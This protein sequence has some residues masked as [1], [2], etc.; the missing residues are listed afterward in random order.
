MIT[1]RAVAVKWYPTP[2][3]FLHDAVN[4]VSYKT[5]L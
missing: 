4:T 5:K 3:Q 2:K 1:A